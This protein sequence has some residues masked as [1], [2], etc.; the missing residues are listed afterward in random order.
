MGKSTTGGGG[1][2][3]RPGSMVVR[4]KLERP[5]LKHEESQLKGTVVKDL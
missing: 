3:T 5:W 1:G 2:V 4:R